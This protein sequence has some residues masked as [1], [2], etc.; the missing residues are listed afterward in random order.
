[1]TSADVCLYS[2][3]T[4]LNTEVLKLKL[5]GKPIVPSSVKDTL[6]HVWRLQDQNMSS[7]LS[8]QCRRS[9]MPL[10]LLETSRR[11]DNE[12]QSVCYGSDL[13]STFTVLLERDS[14]LRSK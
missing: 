12:T 10:S 4:R 13:I 8:N 5:T 3:A 14:E 9:Q 7:H 11:G 1:M 6:T 2:K